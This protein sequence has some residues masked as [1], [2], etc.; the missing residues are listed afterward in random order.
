MGWMPSALYG[1]YVTRK[2]LGIRCLA[3]RAYAAPVIM[4]RYYDSRLRV[5]EERRVRA[6]EQRKKWKQVWIQ[7]SNCSGT[8]PHDITAWP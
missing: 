3:F 6:P 8:S 1:V 7:S 5:Y 2:G 4:L